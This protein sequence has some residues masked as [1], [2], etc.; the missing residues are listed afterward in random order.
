MGFRNVSLIMLPQDFSKANPNQAK[1][2]NQTKI[3]CFPLGFLESV[4]YNA[5]EKR[6]A[7][8]FSSTHL[9]EEGC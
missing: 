4:G 6:F 3:L 2:M 9:N 5:V 8:R 1:F 7:K